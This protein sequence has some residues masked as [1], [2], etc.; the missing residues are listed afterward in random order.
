M[1]YGGFTYRETYNMPVSYKRWFIQ[2]IVKELTKGKDDSPPPR[3]ADPETR[4]MLG[5]S[6]PE[7]PP[8]LRRFT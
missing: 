6:R 1:Y 2:R 8:R 4:A 3:T 5:M 7:A